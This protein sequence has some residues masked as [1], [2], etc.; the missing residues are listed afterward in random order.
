MN[1]IVPF[2]LKV[3]DLEQTTAFYQQVFGFKEGSVPRALDTR[4]RMQ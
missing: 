3:D 4:L 2:A 1:R